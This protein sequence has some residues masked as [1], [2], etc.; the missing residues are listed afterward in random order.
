MK[1]DS[2]TTVEELKQ[3]IRKFIADRRWEKYH[4]PKDIAE[5]ICIE[6]AELMEIFQWRGIDE[7]QIL[8]RKQDFRKR[9]AEE[10]A[11]VIIY[12]L[13]MVN[14][15]NVDLTDAIVRKLEKNERKYSVD[16]YQGK[17]HVGD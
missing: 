10:L 13:S 2:K 12:S 14:T 1:N 9:I 15:T 4:H 7:I 6:A 5:S 8:M 17:A 3:M 11:D 16:E